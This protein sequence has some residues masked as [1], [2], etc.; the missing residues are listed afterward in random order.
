M[1]RERERYIQEG[2]EKGETVRELVCACV[3]IR[4]RERE[5]DLMCECV[6]VRKCER[7]RTRERG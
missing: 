2:C 3:C 1:E 4:E 6:C 7:D 5:R